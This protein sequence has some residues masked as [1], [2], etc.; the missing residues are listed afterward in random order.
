MSPAARRCMW[1]VCAAI[2]MLDSVYCL[3]CF[4]CTLSQEGCE[5]PTKYNI[6]TVDCKKS[7]FT[8]VPD[9]VQARMRGTQGDDDFECLT[10]I[11]KNS[12]HRFYTRRCALRREQILCELRSR[13]N[14]DLEFEK[15][16]LCDKDYCNSSSERRINVVF[17]YLLSVLTVV[18][19][20]VRI[21]Y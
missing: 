7:L 16:S 17:I 12:T 13:N 14:Y 11:E 4:E 19:F 8:I 5:D 2:V 9:N 20:V 21:N 10:T 1:N 15:C 18:K 6:P 3:Q